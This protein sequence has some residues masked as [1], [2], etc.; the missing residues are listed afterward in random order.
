MKSVFPSSLLKKALVADA[1]V[2]GAVAA[3]QVALPD[4]L[5]RLLMLPR[6]L[7]VESGVF[8]VA[9]TVL[10]V[11]LARSDRVWSGLVGFIVLGNV[12]WAAGC[13]L[14]PATGLVQPGPLGL[15]FVGVQAVTVLV[16]AALEYGGLRA[17]S[18]AAPPAGAV[19]T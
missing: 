3:L 6:A 9:Y 12:G 14:L 4:T 16:F 2:S 18:L 11:V 13:L 7:L 17:S 19:R 5:G 15:A 10:L 1:V 8:L